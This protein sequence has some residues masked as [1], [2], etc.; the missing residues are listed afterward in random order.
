M[1]KVG[2]RFIEVYREDTGLFDSGFTVI[3]D[4]TTGVNYLCA[5]N[6]IGYGI[7]PLL[8][9]EGKIVVSALTMERDK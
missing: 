3:V 4:K 6:G 2:R 8:D 7:T 1:K 9:S 5:C